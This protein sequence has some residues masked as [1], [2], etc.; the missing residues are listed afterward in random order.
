MPSEYPLLPLRVCFPGGINL[1]S[2]W[3]W[4]IVWMARSRTRDAGGNIT[5]ES[6]MTRRPPEFVPVYPSAEL[7]PVSSTS[8]VGQTR[9]RAPT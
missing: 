2:A 5:T 6:V 1:G 4:V 3:G 7:T 9:R 8:V